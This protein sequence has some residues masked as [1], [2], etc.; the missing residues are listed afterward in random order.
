VTVANLIKPVWNKTPPK[1][2]LPEF[3]SWFRNFRK[4]VHYSPTAEQWEELQK[5]M[6][7]LEK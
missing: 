2:T 4:R 7:A 6:E 3:L 1:I 5:I